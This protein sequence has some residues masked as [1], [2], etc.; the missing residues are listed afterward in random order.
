LGWNYYYQHFLT[1]ERI[2]DGVRFWHQYHNTLA[3][4]SNAYGVPED[5]IVSILGIESR[6]G[7]NTGR[8]R[9][10]DSLSTLAFN[11]PDRKAYF[12]G[13]LAQFLLFSQ[14]TNLNPLH[15]RGSWA[16]AI[17]WP[18]FMPGNA[19]HYAI[20]MDHDGKSDILNDPEDAIGSVANYFHQQ[21]W[22]KDG[23]IAIPVKFASP[24]LKGMPLEGTLRSFLSNGVQLDTTT[25]MPLNIKARLIILH[26][27]KHTEYWLGFHNLEV[28]HEYN[29]SMYYTMAAYELAHAI[30]L[31]YKK[32]GYTLN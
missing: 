12:K 28:L 18:Q 19:R 2:H 6:Y 27:P 30:K 17:G 14:E 29:H 8:Y 31:A 32:K 5:L 9:A 23:P 20:D 22:Q 11:Y 24:P 1:P 16:G 21:G 25:R 7:K 3:Q 13:E 26:S 15:I 10:I 4:A